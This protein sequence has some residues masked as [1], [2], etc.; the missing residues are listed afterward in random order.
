MPQNGTYSPPDMPA[1]DD[2]LLLLW[3]RHHR[4]VAEVAGTLAQIAVDVGAIKSRI[5]RDDASQAAH[6]ALRDRLVE[7]GKW[8]VGVVLTVAGL[9]LT[10]YR[11]TH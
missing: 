2:A 5:V 3:D 10:H 6:R 7:L 11:L 8:A 1:H 4:H 9:Y